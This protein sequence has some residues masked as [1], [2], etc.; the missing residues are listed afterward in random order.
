MADPIVQLWLQEL[1]LGSFIG[2]FK[3]QGID[4]HA[5]SDLTEAHFMELGIVR[6]GDRAKLL[7]KLSKVYQC[8][9]M[10]TLC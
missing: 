2:V 4:V 6:V 10:N 7:G 1:G 8:A 9:R 5:L 3:D